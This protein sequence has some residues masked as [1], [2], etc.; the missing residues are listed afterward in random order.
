MQ[1]PSEGL[2]IKLLEQ[3]ARSARVTTGR[4]SITSGSFVKPGKYP[5]KLDWSLP[6]H[7][8]GFIYCTE[9]RTDQAMLPLSSNSKRGAG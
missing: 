2:E 9:V 6:G 7:V 3:G 8:L 4:V 1:K 5:S